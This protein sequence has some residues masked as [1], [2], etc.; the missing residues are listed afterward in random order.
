MRA[1]IRPS[2]SYD[3]KSHPLH[4]KTQDPYA[5]NYA[6]FYS[7]QG[8]V[9][10]P[11]L[12]NR[13]A[14]IHKILER[15]INSFEL[16]QHIPLL[17]LPPELRQSEHGSLLLMYQ[18]TI[19][20]ASDIMHLHAILLTEVCYLVYAEKIK[21]LPQI[22]IPYF[23]YDHSSKSFLIYIPTFDSYTDDDL[24]KWE[25]RSALAW[26]HGIVRLH[27]SYATPI[28]LLPPQ[29]VTQGLS[30]TER[31]QANCIEQAMPAFA[32]HTKSQE[33]TLQ[34]Q[35]AKTQHTKKKE[36]V[37]SRSLK[38]NDAE[39]TNLDVTIG[40]LQT[41]PAEKNIFTLLLHD[42]LSGLDSSSCLRIARKDHDY[43]KDNPFLFMARDLSSDK[44]TWEP[45]SETYM[46]DSLLLLNNIF[47][48]RYLESHVEHIKIYLRII[49]SFLNTYPLL[50]GKL[51]IL[52][53]LTENQSQTICA[54]FRCKTEED[55][56]ILSGTL[57]RNFINCHR[58]GNKISFAH[59]I[60][61]P[62]I[63]I[64]TYS[65]SP[66]EMEGKIRQ[67]LSQFDIAIRYAIHQA[68]PALNDYVAS[69]IGPTIKIYDPFNS[70][71]NFPCAPSLTSSKHD[72]VLTP[73]SLLTLSTFSIFN[74]SSIPP[75]LPQLKG[76][77]GDM[78]PSLYT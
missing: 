51:T 34:K 46:Y 64:C 52:R 39:V 38:F 68:I 63:R 14:S 37:H 18:I 47:I 66:S 13:A 44:T 20:C 48:V 57:N 24:I 4:F 12:A 53:S 15:M 71:K 67:L 19:E 54:T 41:N 45:S 75:G 16:N 32:S 6:S 33:N 7:P 26:T 61:P 72:A 55:A 1:T 9:N 70:R 56:V 42:F 23:R 17:L 31:K 8:K 69:N 49:A 5:N 78:T 74:W 27:C 30:A 11:I 43:I 77:E 58:N 73:T 36:R 62:E 59:H 28:P 50:N 10:D 2:L 21:E 40:Y 65:T 25:R 60:C 35:A 76:A 3:A 22:K 29:L